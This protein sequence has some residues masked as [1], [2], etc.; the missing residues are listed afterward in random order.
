MLLLSPGSQKSFGGVQALRGA[1]LTCVRGEVHALIG[2]NGAGK[3]TLVKVLAGAV[4]PDGGQICL[5]GE[6]LSLRSPGDAR[7]AG[8]V[9]VFQ[10]LSLIPDHTRR[11]QSL[12]RHR[13]ACSR[14]AHRR[15]CAASELP[16]SALDEL[17]LE[18]DR[19]RPHDPLARPRRAAD[20]RDRKGVRPQT[21]RCSCSTS[22]RRRC[23]P[24]RSAGCSS[25]CGRSR[26]DGGIVVFISHRL[27]E[28][29][30]L[31]DRVTVF[32]GGDRRRQR[33]RSARC[34]KALLV[35]LMLGRKVERFYPPSRSR[36]AE[37]ASVVCSV[38]DLASP[39]GLR[40]VSLEIRGRRDRRRRRSPGA[41]A[42]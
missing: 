29:E 39:P 38:V 2:E 37:R 25:G 4:R 11:H 7:R 22:R 31:A 26:Q 10:E 23:F 30:S 18:L 33:R 15:T 6:P 3:S 35:E 12:L 8:I 32:R 17:G 13:A 40:G 42:G 14:R 9:T 20:G 16:E 21:R 19:P 24:S 5:N 28:I 34:P 36:A 27:E 1:S 41:R